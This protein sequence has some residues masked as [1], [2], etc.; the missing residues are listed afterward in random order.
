MM[1]P[2]G[3]A[4]E[5]SRGRYAAIRAEQGIDCFAKFVHRPVEIAMAAPNRNRGLIHPP[6][7]VDG[8]GIARP[9]T[10]EFGHILL[11]PAVNGRVRNGNASLGEHFDKVSIAQAVRQVPANA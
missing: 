2:Q 3:L 4:K 10:L 5:G 11:D 6:R 1:C 8:L 7:R 9:P